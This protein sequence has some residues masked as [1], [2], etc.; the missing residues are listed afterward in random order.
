MKQASVSIVPLWI[1][2]FDFLTA[3]WSNTLPVEV[4]HNHT[5][6]NALLTSMKN[7]LQGI[8]QSC[9]LIPTER[10]FMFL[11]DISVYPGDV[12]IGV[13]GTRLDCVSH[14]CPG[15][16]MMVLQTESS[17]SADGRAHSVVTLN[18]ASLT[19]MTASPAPSPASVHR[20]LGPASATSALQFISNSMKRQRTTD[21]HSYVDLMCMLVC[22]F[23]GL[24][25]KRNRANAADVG[26]SRS[27]DIHIAVDIKLNGK[28]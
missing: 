2:Q 15:D 9:F 19:L 13:Q 10:P 26:M 28:A 21:H 16:S 5:Y 3:V 12:I 20:R 11:V 17:C 22:H 18:A 24:V 27:C 4:W 8:D 6:N 25:G 7:I 23:V 1:V 14:T